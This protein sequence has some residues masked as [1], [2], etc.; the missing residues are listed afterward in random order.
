MTDDPFETLSAFVDG[1]TRDPVALAAALA[2]PGAREAL[3]DFVLLRAAVQADTSVPRARALVGVR[4]ETRG[5]RGARRFRARWLVAA[6]AAVLLAAGLWAI[7]PA[8]KHPERA[9]TPPTPTRDVTFDVWR[10]RS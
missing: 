3:V 9:A 7:R 1:E 4:A 6:A 8:A 2:A 10:A 5:P